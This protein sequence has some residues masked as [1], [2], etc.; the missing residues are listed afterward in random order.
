[1]FQQTDDLRITQVR[2]LIPPAILLEEIP[3]TERAS[4][5][6]SDTRRAVAM[7]KKLNIPTLGIIENMAYFVCPSCSHEA[8][9]FGR[10]GGKRAGRRRQSLS[11][12]AGEPD[13]GGARRRAE[14]AVGRR[15]ARVAGRLGN[16]RHGD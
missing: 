9:I 8:D 15:S 10:G 13:S 2:P 4:N 7:Y 5:V 14:A 16:V 12:R 3:L 1:M 11:Q 6:V